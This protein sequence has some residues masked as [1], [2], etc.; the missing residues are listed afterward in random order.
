MAAQV[1]FSL[2]PALINNGIIDYTTPEGAKL[3]HATIEA[4]PVTHSTANPMG[5]RF[6]LQ[7]WRTKQ[8]DAVGCIF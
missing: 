1:Q 5:S 3:Y 4:L 6:S 8:A 7:H 2:V